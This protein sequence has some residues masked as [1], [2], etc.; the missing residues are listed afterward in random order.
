MD[1]IVLRL[2]RQTAIDL[3]D[4]IYGTGEHIAAGAP[5]PD[6]DTAANER[7]ATVLNALEG[8]LRRGG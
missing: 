4:L 1:D 5:L 2:D 6:F 8:E 3:R 7:L